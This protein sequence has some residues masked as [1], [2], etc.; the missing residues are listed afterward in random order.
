MC[1]LPQ[2]AKNSL[3]SKTNQDYLKEVEVVVNAKFPYSWHDN[4]NR[5]VDMLSM[6]SLKRKATYDWMKKRLVK[7]YS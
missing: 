2:G 1:T 7:F 4:D 5:V 3:P 6:Q